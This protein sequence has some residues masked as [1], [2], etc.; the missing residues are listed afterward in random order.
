MT[1]IF[2]LVNSQSQSRIKIVRILFFS[3]FFYIIFFAGLQ[4]AQVHI[5]S[6][7]FMTR[8]YGQN[9]GEDWYFA[10][11]SKIKNTDMEL[12]CIYLQTLVVK[13]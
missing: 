2:S 3:L 12:N 5:N 13:L 10:I 7:S 9:G 6:L 1:M 8:T 11:I 4:Y